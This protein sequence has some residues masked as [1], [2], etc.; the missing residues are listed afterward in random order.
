MINMGSSE[1]SH[2]TPRNENIRK[3]L[4]RKKNVRSHAQANFSKI[5]KVEEPIASGSRR[6]QL[7]PRKR[8]VFVK[9]PRSSTPSLD[10]CFH[11]EHNH[12]RP[13]CAYMDDE[14]EDV[15][16]YAAW[17]KEADNPHLIVENST[18]GKMIHGMM[19]PK[20]FPPGFTLTHERANAEMMKNFRPV[21]VVFMRR[22]YCPVIPFRK[23]FYAV[24]T[25][26]AIRK[27]CNP[28]GYMM[29]TKVPD[30]HQPSF[31]KWFAPY[32]YPRGEN[33]PNPPKTIVNIAPIR[34]YDNK[35]KIEN[36]QF[37]EMTNYYPEYNPQYYY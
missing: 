29:P 7:R 12:N 17:K 6:R 8:Q 18:N 27:Y 9:L 30:A 21:P 34:H 35:Q 1:S 11:C 22:I 36:P 15:P 20:H 5:N 13:C 3:K 4:F 25:Q 10:I 2:R 24:S 23:I 14:P 28:F 32:I 37:I 31:L 19:T 16:R 26:S 33:V